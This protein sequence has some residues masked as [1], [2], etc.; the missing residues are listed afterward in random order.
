MT[1]LQVQQVPD[2]DNPE[3]TFACEVYTNG[4]YVRWQALRATCLE[5]AEAE[6]VQTFRNLN[7]VSVNE[8][9]LVPFYGEP[10]YDESIPF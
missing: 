10:G 6:A 2:A 1:T 8:I 5:H 7:P 3:P 4:N 9:N